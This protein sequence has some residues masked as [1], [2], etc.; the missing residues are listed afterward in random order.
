[1]ST[2]EFHD[3]KAMFRATAP[4]RLDFAGAWT[5]VAPFTLHE[6]G[7]VVSGAIELR[8]TAELTLGG[9]G[10]RLHADD[11]GERL[12]LTGSNAL[13]GDGQLI[14][15]RAALRASR[16][17]PCSLRTTSGAP[18]GAGLGGSG[19][20][21]VAL[22][23]AIDR[24]QRRVRSVV[25]IADEAWRIETVEAMLAGGKQDQYTAAHGGFN[26][27]AF[28]GEQVAVRRLRVDPAFADELARHTIVC[29]TGRT[30]FSPSTI[31]RVMAAYIRGDPTVERALRAMVGLGEWMADALERSDLGAVGTL[32]GKNWIEQ[33]RLDA[34]MRTNAMAR[35]E[36]AMHDAGAIG[37]K[38]AGAGAGGSMFFVV[39][40]PAAATRA[41]RE[42][43]ATVLPVRWASDGVQTQLVTG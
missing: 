25:E 39:R 29:F 3:A 22:V 19:A 23:A 26:H 20:L 16:V 14:L 10:Y 43:D 35:L 41:A 34:G 33:Q 4:M 18:A 2:P 15:L 24:A 9:D 6:R 8:A 32:L 42:C 12:E 5:D 7:V 1:M 17:G 40:D 28:E 21:G 38:A 30:R 37:G 31:A 13:A 36:Q 27:L 11:L